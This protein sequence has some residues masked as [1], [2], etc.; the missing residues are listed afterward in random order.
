MA[1][2]VK[3]DVNMVQNTMREYDL[4][5]SYWHVSDLKC[6]QNIE[7]HALDGDLKYLCCLSCQSAILGYQIISVST[8]H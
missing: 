8:S 2:K 4:L 5:Q 7:V 3:N 1:T 6:F